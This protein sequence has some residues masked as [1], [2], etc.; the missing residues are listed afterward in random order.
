MLPSNN[1]SMVVFADADDCSILAMSAFPGIKPSLISPLKVVVTL[2]TSSSM[3]PTSAIT[4]AISSSI[5]LRPSA[6]ELACSFDRLMSS[7]FLPQ[8][9]SGEL[10]KFTPGER[11]VSIGVNL[12][13]DTLQS[14]FV[15]F[16]GVLS[17]INPLSSS[18]AVSTSISPMLNRLRSSM[19]F[20]TGD[21]GAAADCVAGFGGGV[22]R[23]GVGATDCK[24]TLSIGFTVSIGLG[25]DVG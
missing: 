2:A 11:V 7:N 23:G 14:F 13:I 20:S 4:D 22:V 25:E 9:G 10:C 18:C 21:C 17:K 8:E 3:A 1:D 6:S 24:L 16:V 15:L 12:A 5:A 19:P